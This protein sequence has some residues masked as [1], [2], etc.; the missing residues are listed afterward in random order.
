MN[1]GIFIAPVTALLLVACSD[2]E[3]GQNGTNGVNSLVSTRV[4]AKGDATCAG[5]GLLLETGLDGNR[6]NALEPG[7]VIDQ[8][9]LQCL[10]APRLRALH[11]SPDA[12]PVNIRVNGAQALANVDY[13]QGSG[14]LNVTEATQ[15]QVEAIIPGGNAVVIDRRLALEFSTDYTV[16]AVGE[17]ADPLDALVVSNPSGRAIAPGNLRAQVV[18][19]APNAPAVDVYVTAPG[20]TL[21][22]STTLN[23]GALDFGETTGRAE[24]P[25]GDYRIRVT[26]AGNPAAV[27]FDSGTV[28]LAAGADLLIAAIENTGP[29]AT[30]IQLVTLNGSGSAKILDAATPASV[31]AVHASPDAP[32]VD[33][34]ADVVGTANNE[35]LGLAR[36]VSFP[37]VCRIP[38]V[39]APGSYNISVTPAGNPGV[40]ALQFPLAP[41]KGNELTAIVTGYLGSTPAL[42]PLA[43]VTSTRGI[44]TEARLRVTHASPGTG[45]VDL[46]LLPDGASL[47]SATA[48]FAAVPFGADTGVL[49]LAPATYDVYVTPAGN[50]SVVAIEVQNLALAGGAVLDVIARDANQNGSEGSLPQLI[51]VDYA[52]VSACST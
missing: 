48:S 50:K 26:A 49:S 6:N 12:P 32:A 41:Q 36:N 14:F 25:A 1:K 40:T 10:T 20:A 33:L 21:A 35:A 37:Q 28:A 39:P 5:G 24:V 3:D 45:N 42:R 11:A 15:V 8:E 27:V 47:A 46:Y 4:I 34:L 16:L 17:V 51:V 18:H 43:L 2:G 38:A 13:G 44:A 52:S 7:E 23:S 29:G 30:P 31:V 22:G 9:Y 19:A